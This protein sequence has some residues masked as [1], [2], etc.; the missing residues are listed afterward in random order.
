MEL[1]IAV[2]RLEKSRSLLYSI[3]VRNPSV[4]EREKKI[5]DAVVLQLPQNDSEPSFC[6]LL[7][8]H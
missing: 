4:G 5:K 6:P 1:C 3:S 7:K 2:L 8:N